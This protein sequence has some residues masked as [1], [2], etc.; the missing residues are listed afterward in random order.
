MKDS[1]WWGYFDVDLVF[2]NISKFLKDSY[3]DSYDRIFTHGALTL[4]RNNNFM[5]N[6][7]NYNFNLP[8]VPNFSTVAT[9][10]AIFAFD[11]W[12]W[13][14]NKGR[15]ISYAVQHLPS[16]RQFDDTTLFADLN[17]NTFNFMTANGEKITKLKY[18]HGDV[19]GFDGDRNE[20]HYLY[21]HFQK[22][23][24]ANKVI[25]YNQ[26]IYITPNTFSNTIQNQSDP[27]QEKIIW[28]KQHKAQR[29]K[30]IMK[31]LFSYSYLWRRLHFFFSERKI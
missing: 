5:N 29:R 12:G 27:Q 23:K 18:F 20:R 22:R 6:L 7:W 8:E 11:E 15:G 28:R 24:M 30:Q 21:A 14:K 19:I 17:P 16:V 25:D 13:G 2:G 1:D 26:P 31:N 4:Y 9:H 3:L 10:T